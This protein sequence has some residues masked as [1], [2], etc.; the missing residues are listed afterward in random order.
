MCVWGKIQLP[1]NAFNYQASLVSGRPKGKLP[2]SCAWPSLIIIRVI[3][4]TN[5]ASGH[6]QQTIEL[7]ADEDEDRKHWAPFRMKKLVHQKYLRNAKERSFL[8]GVLLKL[9]TKMSYKRVVL[10]CNPFACPVSVREAKKQTPCLA[11]NWLLLFLL[12]CQLNPRCKFL[13]S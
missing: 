6:E 10:K 4:Y 12:G 8:F 5:I 13:R 9:F 2:E 1:N 7:L 3:F 11:N